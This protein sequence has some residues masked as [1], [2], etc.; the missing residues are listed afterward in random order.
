MQLDAILRSL[1]RLTDKI[2]GKEEVQVLLH[3]VSRT[4]SR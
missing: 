4:G 3:E 2:L 1:Q